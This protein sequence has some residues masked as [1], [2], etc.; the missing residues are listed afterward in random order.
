MNDNYYAIGRD[1]YVSDITDGTPTIRI[2]RSHYGLPDID[3][4]L[5]ADGPLV[6][7]KALL[8]VHT[9]AKEI[10]NEL[11]ERR[12]LKPLTDEDLSALGK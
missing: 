4:K 7:G 5:A 8:A 12:G 3:F 6:L 10:G 9:L 11:R 1:I 2:D